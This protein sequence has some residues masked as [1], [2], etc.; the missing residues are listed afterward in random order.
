MNDNKLILGANKMKSFTLTYQEFQIHGQQTGR[1]KPLLFLHGWGVSSAVMIP[2]AQKLG[3]IRCCTLIDLPGF[4]KT[5]IP[6]QAWSVDDYTDMVEYLINEYFEPPVDLLVHSFG[7]RIALKLC[8][9]P[10]SKQLVDKVIITGGAGMKPRRSL[11]YYLK[12]YT[13]KTLKLPFMILPSYTRNSALAKLRKTRLWKALGSSDYSKLDGVMREVFVKTVTDYLDACLPDIPHEVLLIWG[14]KDET[15]P[16]Y[17]G[18]RMEKGIRNA[19]LVE[20]ANAGHYAFLD[21]P[22]RFLAI[23]RAFLDDEDVKK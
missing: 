23:A 22:R 21:Q 3:D 8:S 9:R 16:I 12:K 10:G 11:P 15:T 19:A 4:G 13:A 5:G 20:I 6:P 18:R 1:G 2:L 14:E 7:G 17:Q